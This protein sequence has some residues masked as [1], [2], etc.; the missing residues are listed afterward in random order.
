L[1]ACVCVRLFLS[2][3]I[4]TKPIELQILTPIQ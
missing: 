2:V 4:I 3:N 1:S